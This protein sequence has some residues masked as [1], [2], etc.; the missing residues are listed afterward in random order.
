MKT[1]NLTNYEVKIKEQKDLTYGDVEDI[2]FNLL[3]A[4]DVDSRGQM[5][6]VRGDKMKRANRKLAKKMIVEIK[7]EDG[8]DVEYSD[9]WL[10]N[11]KPA[12][13]GMELMNEINEQTKSIGKKKKESK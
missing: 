4:V 12:D 1:L 9:K 5:K 8:N 11:M 10:D 13:D 7:D 2:Q 6:S 3:D